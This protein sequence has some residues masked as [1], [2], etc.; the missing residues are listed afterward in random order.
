MGAI[1]CDYNATTPLDPE[2]R[3]AMW[4]FLT[5]IWGNP[6][7]LHQYGRRA[8]AALDEARE[9][10]AAVLG[11][12]PTEIIFTSGGTE[13]VNLAVLGAARA[14]RDKG[15]HLVTSAIEHHAVLEAMKY[16]EQYEGFRVTRLPVTREGF[17]DPDH[18]AAALEPDT[19]LV[20]IMAANNEIGTIQPV[21]ELA[22]LCHERGIW[23]HTDA[24]QFF[25]KMPFD[26]VRDLG[27]D[28]VSLCAHKFHGPKG[29][30]LLYVR[31]PL[32]VQPLLFGG[33]HENENRA[34]TENLAAIAG[35]VAAM[36][37]F[38]HPPVFEPR[39]MQALTETLTE[40]LLSVPGVHLLS[41]RSARLPN[42]VAVGVE[43]LDS[44]T[45]VAGLDLE[46][47]CA[48][49]GSACSA[50]AMEPSH[51]A[52]AL[53]VP[54]QVAAGLVRFSLGRENT[55]EDIPRIAHAFRRVVE[56]GRTCG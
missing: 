14:L 9:R 45:L 21:R 4:P 40:A 26:S 2:V 28:L 37:R 24:V 56:R 47:V 15:R 32:R 34:G 23:F 36:E 3:S 10:A 27:A 52:T 11:A 25:G 39:R 20:S 53:G 51:V 44:V 31:S 38:L 5:E 17:V 30:G 42:T 54:P 16:L 8:R 7:S 6:S 18:L 22:A 33:P 41:P 12:K 50:G 29:A 48:S 1:Y 55:D 35:L 19:V 46:G 49:A 43:G 13:S